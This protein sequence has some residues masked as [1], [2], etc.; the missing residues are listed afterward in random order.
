MLALVDC[1][2]ILVDAVD[3]VEVLVV[4][5]V[6]VVRVAHQKWY[7]PFQCWGTTSACSDWRS[8]RRRR[9][10]TPSSSEDFRVTGSRSQR[11]LRTPWR[12][13]LQ[14][15]GGYGQSKRVG[16]VG[17][18]HYSLGRRR[19]RPASPLTR[20]YATATRHAPRQERP[21]RRI[22]HQFQP[23][24]RTCKPKKE[25]EEREREREVIKRNRRV[26]TIYGVQSPWPWRQV[27]THQPKETIKKK[28]HK[29]RN[30]NML[31]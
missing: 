31:T 14:R 3:A 19:R 6:L 12:R 4:V 1:G 7:C 24:R 15:I 9:R 25:V 18:G 20:H 26:E 5:V 23:K 2:G 13:P 22:K 8:A 10:W 17:G 16:A 30:V 29:Q 28:K 21:L 27:Q 11:A